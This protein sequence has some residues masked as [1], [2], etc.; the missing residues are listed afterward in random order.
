MKDLVLAP[1]LMPSLLTGERTM[2]KNPQNNAPVKHRGRPRKAGS[3]KTNPREHIIATAIK[4]F[5]ERGYAKTSLSEIARQIGLDQSSLY[6][7]FSS[8]EAILECIF[9]IDNLEDFVNYTKE[10][11]TSA[12][13]KVYSLIVNDV[14]KK[15]ELPF[16]F[17]ELELLAHDNPKRF[18]S[19]LENYRIYYQTLVEII[20]QGIQ[21][22]EFIT[23]NA[24][25]R[26]VT[27]LSINEGLQH[28][29]HAKQRGELILES[30]GYHVRNHAPE[31]IGHMAALSILPA[32]VSKPIN[33]ENVRKESRILM[34]TF[35]VINR[36][37]ASKEQTGLHQK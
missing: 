21:S 14:I 35:L 18:G 12:T 24:D 9:N 30:T 33:I 29:F 36:H 31:D 6:Y 7:W 25:E 16:D 27:I 37:G 3:T 13:V 8:K 4:L 11:Q 34:R 15:C 1:L 19:L 23:C 20:E 32:L 10:I 5:Q 17:F 22:G 28:H 2:E 26:A